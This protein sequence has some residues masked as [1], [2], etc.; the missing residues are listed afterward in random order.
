MFTRKLKDHFNNFAG[1]VAFAGVYALAHAAQA[2]G[3]PVD[4]ALTLAAAGTAGFATG[5][6]VKETNDVPLYTAG[7][8]AAAGTIGMLALMSRI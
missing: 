8:S 4:P 6:L 1:I 2:M 7:V 5:I 3:V